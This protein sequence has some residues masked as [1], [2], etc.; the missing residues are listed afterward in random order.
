MR[1]SL[2]VPTATSVRTVPA[3]LLEENR[4]VLNEHM[5][6]RAL[7]KT[8]FTHLIAFAIVRALREQP[9]MQSAFA[10]RDGR[11]QR[12]IPRHVHLGLAIDLEGGGAGRELVVPTLKRA[13]ELDFRAF[14]AAY[15]ALV[16]LARGKELALADFQGTTATL[17]NPGGFGTTLSV[18]RLMPGQGLIV[19]IGAI[20]PPPEL[21]GLAPRT[22]AELALG[23]VLTLTSTYDHRVIQGAESAL[24]LQRVA[25]LLQGADGFYDGIFATLRVPWT[26][27]RAAGDE[28]AHAECLQTGVWALIN[29]YRVRGCRLADLDPLEYRPDRLP[30]LDPTTYGIT[31]WDMEREFDCAGMLGETRMKLRD[32]LAL[33]RRAYCRRWTVEYMHISEHRPKHWIRDYVEDP[34][35]Q[36]QFEHSDQ[37]RFL[38]RLAQAENF[39]RFLHARY[40]GNKRFSLEG[41]DTL[42]PALCAL[43]ERAAEGGVET[44]VL[45]MAH[46]GRLNVLAN[47]LGLSHAEI[48]AEF[49]GVLLPL[50]NEGSGDVKYH[51]GQRGTFV[52]PTGREVEVVLSPNPS[53]LEAVDPVVTGMARALQDVRGDRER[54]RVLAVLV[55]GDAAFSGQGVVAETLN[56]S[57]LRAYDCGGTLHVVLNNQIGFTTGPRDLRS[58]YYC[59]DVAKSIDAPILHANGDY[60]ESVARA[61]RVA[62]D[63][64]REFR[65]DA[66]V[67]MVCYRRRGHNEGDEPA[68]TQP[69][70]YERIRA[71][72]TV[73]EGYEALLFRREQLTT[74]EAAE[75]GARFE[76]ELKAALEQSLTET[77]PV[78]PEQ[79]LLD[80]EVDD[81][82][83]YVRAPA[84]A[85]GVAR[86][87]LATIVAATNRM[88]EGFVTHPNLLRQLH[89]REE[90]VA[91]ERDVD[92]GCAEALAFGTLLEEGVPIRLAGQDSRRGTFSQRHAL[93]RDQH[94]E[95]EHLP[96]AALARDGASFEAWDALLS[97]EAALAF[98]Y[99]YALA[100]P[101]ALVLWEAQYGDFVNGAQVGI[102]QFLMAGEA[103]WKQRSGLVL[104]LPH[105]H[106]G[107]GPEHTSARPE[108]FLA[109]CSGGYATLVDCSTAAQYFHALRRQGLDPARRPLIVLT[110]KSLLRDK[111]AAS[112][113]ALFGEQE[114]FHELLPDE[115]AQ[116]GGA[117]RVVL[118]SGK[119]YHDLEQFRAENAIEDV[120]LVR[121]EQLYPFPRAELFLLLDRHPDADC[122]FC[123]EEPR[124]QG[125]WPF[126]MQRFFDAQRPIAYC[127]R[128]ESPTPASGSY[129]RHALEQ[130]RLV[131]AA[132]EVGAATSEPRA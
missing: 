54:R 45:G 31:V 26:P 73:R 27:L 104:L 121:V 81:P 34:A 92:W 100:R 11:G 113:L 18:P 41:A 42:I 84:P 1:E 53:H 32:I 71:H 128:P 87:R 97:E 93:I 101:E 20:G 95:A 110:P 6:L 127:G 106:D 80:L 48:F 70:L 37:R 56:M 108:R 119:V 75:I 12:R 67:D 112:P 10:E 105:G 91:G 16:R 72:P 66:V 60:P 15:E 114:R 33:L 129:Q 130:A 88:P 116:R 125:F 96:L 22:L 4:R 38:E 57:A 64:Q 99:G 111:R 86:E 29:A 47:V 62:V 36:I 89:R 7:G 52:T 65:R 132:F 120:A 19:G 28:P 102:D 23:P 59:T 131:R 3:K 61:V 9:R 122:V 8:S 49:E 24:F 98:E 115:R 44:V 43:I 123:Q 83:D 58:T 109:L 25:E 14:H 5:E 94:T 117:R 21:A 107:Q 13:E 35:R 50:E 76:G 55:H 90:M 82:A 46:R 126:V 78:P 74:E 79:A 103:K 39:E 69:L 51:R 2:E 17:T 118:C 40:V 77:R 85:T 63:Y 124:N 30:S 68:F